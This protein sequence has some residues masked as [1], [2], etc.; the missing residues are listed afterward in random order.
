M[1]QRGRMTYAPL[2][3][4]DFKSGCEDL[5][6]EEIGV[7]LRILFE[8]YEAMG[9]IEFDERRLAKRLNS[10][11]HKARAMVENLICKRKLYLTPAGLISNHRAEDEISKFVSISVQNQLNAS[12]NGINQNSR[13]KKRN[14]FSKSDERPQSDRSHILEIRNKNITTSEVLAL[15]SREG[16]SPSEKAQLAL[17]GYRRRQSNRQRNGR[18]N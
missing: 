12:S 7:Y 3:I 18:L 16:L 15:P 1:K 9:P 14:K 13:Q 4:E 6:N 5:T 17:E 8:I 11:P 10:R 2:Y